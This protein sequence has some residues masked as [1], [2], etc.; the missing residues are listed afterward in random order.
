MERK[1]EVH[2]LDPWF[3]ESSRVL[4]LGS[5][6][7]PKSRE[8][9]SYYGHPQNRFWKTLAA[10]FEDTV[11]ATVEERQNFVRRHH[12]ALWDVLASCAIRGADDASI[13]QAVA[14][15]ITF[16]MKR[17]SICAVFTTGKKA[18]KLYDELILPHIGVEATALPS[19]SPANRR[20]YSEETLV[21]HY[22]VIRDYCQL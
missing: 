22:R 13:D 14:N 12:I 8:Y 2:T 15:D 18:K 9:G 5:F 4:I 3:D 1:C 16:V 6:P 21:E 10:V 19:T 7:S 20:W 17:A 11:P